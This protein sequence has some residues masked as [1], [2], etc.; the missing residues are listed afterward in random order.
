MAVKGLLNK[1]GPGLMYA[2]AAIGVSHLVQ[3]T[4]AGAEYGYF[5]AAF[6]ILANAIKYPIFEAGPRYVA[7]T[8][9]SLL[10][11][12]RRLGSWA[13]WVFLI[14][15]I[16]TMFT[17]QSAVTVVTAGLAQT[18]TGIEL[19]PQTWSLILL[20]ICGSILMVGKYSLLDKIVKIIIL[21]LTATTI[22]SVV[23][24]SLSDFPKN[25]VKTIFDFSNTS[26]LMFMAALMGWMPAPVD[27][28]IWH[29]I[30]SE[31]RNKES[32]E[33]TSL[34]DASIDFNVGYIGTALLAI[35]FLSLGTMV[36]YGS[37]QNF[38]GSA[39]S[40]AGQ[41][42]KLYTNSLGQWSYP[43][44]AIAAF[45]T[46]FS[47]T[48]TCLDAF[49]R[50]LRE[51]FEQMSPSLPKQCKKIYVKLLIVTIAG[52][53]AVLFLFLKN[54]KTLVDFATTISFVVAPVLGI[55]NIMVINGKS[56]PK[57]YRQPTWLKIFAYVSAAFLVIFSIAYVFIK[58]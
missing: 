18:I 4:R 54:M 49:P 31:A 26:H 15:T 5:M 48:L 43:V 38:S 55:L 46:M 24:G 36:M 33:Q 35:G 11:G 14:M 52:T 44:I 3:S 45:T 25:G 21:T 41:L 34:R 51:T 57:E 42:I 27:I 56:T 40:F 37:G 20:L 13:L 2:G 7:A 12:Y 1:L 19:G 29:S 58:Y 50:V 17:I 23:S 28:S 30:W 8:G 10:G 39:A 6:I 53:V 9:D 22:I 47:T 16:L 32:G